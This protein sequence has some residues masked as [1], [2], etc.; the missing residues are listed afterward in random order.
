MFSKTVNS[1]YQNQGEYFQI[2]YLRFYRIHFLP[3]LPQS[4][5]SLAADNFFQWQA[6]GEKLIKASN[7]TKPRFHF[8][9]K[10]AHSAQLSLHK[11]TSKAFINRRL[12]ICKQS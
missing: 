3:S 6:N 7:L 9:G 12:I 8:L 1:D 5:S 4:F 2:W 10:E 11:C